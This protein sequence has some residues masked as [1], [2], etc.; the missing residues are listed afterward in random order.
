MGSPTYA[1]RVFLEG[2]E[3]ETSLQSELEGARKASG[4]TKIS[5][6]TRASW[7]GRHL[8]AQRKDLPHGTGNLGEVNY[9]S[10]ERKTQ[11]KKNSLRSVNIPHSPSRPRISCPRGH[12]IGQDR[13]LLLTSA[14]LT[15]RSMYL[16]LFGIN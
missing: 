2:P 4:K 1:Q 16:F 3:L 10:A 6:K 9:I 15:S 11:A 7:K 5:V 13:N 14:S 12:Q 8:S